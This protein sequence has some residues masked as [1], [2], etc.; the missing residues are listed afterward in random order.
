M[1]LYFISRGVKHFRD[2]FVTQMQGRFFPWKRKNLKTGVEEMHAVQ[3]A[4][5]PIELWEYVFPEE[6]LPEVI[7]M[8]DAHGLGGESVTAPKR[9]KLLKM[10]MK[11]ALNAESLPKDIKK[12]DTMKVFRNGV[13]IDI[14][15]IK[16]DKKQKNEEWG[17]EQEML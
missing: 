1:H 9:T 10:G 8:L 15:G 16:K 3:G 12:V 11:K 6:S 14:I 13:A 5:R 4:L 17:Y 7:A 2:I